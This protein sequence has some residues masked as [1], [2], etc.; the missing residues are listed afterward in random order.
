MILLEPESPDSF[1]QWGFFH[2]IL[3]PTEYVEGYVME[4]MAEKMLAD[5]PDL[6]RAFTQ[7]LLDD[8]AFAASPEARLQWFYGQTPFADASWRLYPVGRE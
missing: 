7:K 6:R 5:S 1:F 3:Q 4:P 2:E 8:P